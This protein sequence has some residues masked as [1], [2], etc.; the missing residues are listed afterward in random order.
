MT[1][2]FRDIHAHFVYGV[3]DGAKS[4]A[5]MQ[6]MLD[7][8]YMGGV[9]VLYA[10]SHSTPGVDRFPEQVY[11]EHLEEARAYCA[12]RGYSIR[13][14]PGA[15][16]LYTPALKN[17]VERH[18]LVTLGDSDCVLMEFVPDISFRE[19]EEA[20]T[21]LENA[22]YTPILAHVERYACLFSHK[23]YRLKREHKVRYQVNCGTLVKKGLGFFKMRKLRRWFKKELID[24]VASDMHD[25]KA[26]RC[27]M[28]GGASA[29]EKFCSCG[30]IAR[31]MGT[32]TPLQ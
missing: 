13:L 31:L 10:T 22:G 18:P 15:E 4:L 32:Q 12:E 27:R 16:I 5:D 29:L 24:Y 17:Y 7:E 30:Y 6:A 11:R 8:A 9:K 3:D 28:G 2:G 26:R 20:V 1:S 25:L 14:Y 19:I 23:I 21:L